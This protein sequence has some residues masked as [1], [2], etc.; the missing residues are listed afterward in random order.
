MLSSDDEYGRLDAAV[1]RSLPVS[2]Y[3][4]DR[5][6]AKCTLCLLEIVENE[7]G[8]AAAQL[9]TLLSYGLR[10]QVVPVALHLPALPLAGGRLGAEGFGE[11]RRRLQE[12]E[13][14]PGPIPRHVMLSSDDEYG[15]LDAAVVRSLPVSVY[16][17]DRE[18]AKCT[19]CL[20]EIVENEVGAAAA[21]LPTLLSYGLRRQVVPVALH[22]PALPL[23]GGRLGAEGFGEWHRLGTLIF[24]FFYL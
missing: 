23:A 14:S 2:V 5:E 1:V 17:A 24:L 4:A 20:L 8:A 13:L 15:R 9:P 12:F 16:P 7:V 21:Q 18:P 11:Q 6:P 10:R 22:L 3:P 19:L